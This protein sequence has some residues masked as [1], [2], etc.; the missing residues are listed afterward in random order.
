MT[1]CAVF[2][3]ASYPSRGTV[4]APAK[5]LLD[6]FAEGLGDRVAR[7]DLQGELAKDVSFKLG[8]F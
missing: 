2:D 6:A 4:F 1:F 5:C 7:I 3:T 8:T